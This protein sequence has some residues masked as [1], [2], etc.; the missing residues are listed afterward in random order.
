MS[1]RGLGFTGGTVDNLKAFRVSKCV[2]S[3]ETIV[4]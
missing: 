1:G 2:S 3:E 4:L